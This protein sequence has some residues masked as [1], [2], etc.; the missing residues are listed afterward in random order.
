MTPVLLGGGI[1]T[2]RTLN[3]TYP[4]YLP[5]PTYLL[6]PLHRARAEHA[7]VITPD[8]HPQSNPARVCYT[9]RTSLCVQSR[10]SAL[11]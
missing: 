3:L 11:D 6:L 10:V 2:A 1:C 4:R 7:E 9:L 5:P 8:G